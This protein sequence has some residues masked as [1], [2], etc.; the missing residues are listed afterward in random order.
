ML[1]IFDVRTDLFLRAVLYCGRWIACRLYAKQD[2][3]N[4]I[5]LS[6]CLRRFIFKAVLFF[7][8]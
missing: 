2:T 4:L 3:R 8:A 5:L 6:F 7:G 1:M